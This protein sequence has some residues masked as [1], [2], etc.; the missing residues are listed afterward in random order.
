M[1]D[2][3]GQSRTTF[4]KVENRSKQCPVKSKKNEEKR[5]MSGKLKQSRKW[6]S[7]V[8]NSQTRASFD[9]KS[10]K[11]TSFDHFGRIM[12]RAPQPGLMS[13]GL[14]HSYHKPKLSL[15]ADDIKN[16]TKK[17]EMEELH[18]N[19]YEQ[20][21]YVKAWLDRSVRNN[22]DLKQLKWKIT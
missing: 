4:D 15:T 12:S 16:G 6:T 14:P 3:V 2:K 19:K 7:F 18:I 11:W 13:K 5:A 9:P 8:S 20:K 10:W 1:S 22:E 21:R 17:R